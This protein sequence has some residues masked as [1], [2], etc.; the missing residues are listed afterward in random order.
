MD[1]ITLNF[2]PGKFSF[3]ASRISCAVPAVVFLNLGVQ[4]DVPKAVTWDHAMQVY[5]NVNN[6]ANQAPPYY[7]RDESD[8]LIGRYFV[9]GFRLKL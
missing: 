6:V 2:T 1:E 8:D 4:Y 9:V 3:R 7:G 5:F